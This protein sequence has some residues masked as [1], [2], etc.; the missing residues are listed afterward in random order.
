M[1]S[2]FITNLYNLWDPKN[3]RLFKPC[4]CFGVWI[5]KPNTLDD[6]LCIHKDQKH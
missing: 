1:I 4:I 3:L 2:L 5:D 6:T